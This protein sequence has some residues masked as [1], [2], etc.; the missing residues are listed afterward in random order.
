LASTRSIA[1]RSATSPI[2]VIR[3]IRV[4]KC[5]GCD[6]FVCDVLASSSLRGCDSAMPRPIRTFRERRG[7]SAGP[8]R[9]TCA[10]TR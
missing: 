6:V 8:R 5:D 3:K 7:G 9:G 1:L 4:Q 2:R 10:R